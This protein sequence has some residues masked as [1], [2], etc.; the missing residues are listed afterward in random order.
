MLKGRQQNTVLIALT[1]QSLSENLKPEDF[2]GRMVLVKKPLVSILR[3]LR[4]QSLCFIS[5]ALQESQWHELKIVIYDSDNRIMEHYDRLIKKLGELEAGLILNENWT[6]D[7]PFVM[8][9]IL[10]YQITILTLQKPW[11]IKTILLGL[12]M[13]ATAIGW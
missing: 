1:D 9:T 10:A 5:S 7:H 12:N 4:Q 2:F 3:Q 8:V 11:F 13:T 6:K